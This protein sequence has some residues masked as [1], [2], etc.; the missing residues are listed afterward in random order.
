MASLKTTIL[1]TLS[2]VVPPLLWA[3]VIFYLS[4]FPSLPSLN[5][6]I[7]DFIFKKS[8]HMF[9]YAVLYLLTWRAIRLLNPTAQPTEKKVWLLAILICFV[10]ALSD[11]YHQS[12]VPNRTAT[13]QD[14]AF[15][16]VGVLLAFLWRYRYI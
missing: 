15:D 11:E 8:A 1:S 3:G 7:L 16:L 14:T 6:S 4:S 2:A 5:L 13:F 10:Y 9:V 12:F